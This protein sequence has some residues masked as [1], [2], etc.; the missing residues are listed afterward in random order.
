M[1]NLKKNNSNSYIFHISILFLLIISFFLD[2][3][4]LVGLKTT[5]SNKY[6]IYSLIIKFLQI[7]FLGFIINIL[8]INLQKRND[9]FLFTSLFISLISLAFIVG[10]V[11]KG[12]KLIKMIFVLIIIISQLICQILRNKRIL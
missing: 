3:L 12:H 1:Y 11:F 4:T 10:L 5:F 9:K 7:L 8:A 6:F 2:K